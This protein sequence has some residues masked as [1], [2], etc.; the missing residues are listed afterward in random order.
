LV[1]RI[2]ID[3]INGCDEGDGDAP[4]VGNR[5]DEALRD[6]WSSAGGRQHRVKVYSELLGSDAQGSSATDPGRLAM[7]CK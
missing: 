1:G 2:A 4:F 3:E 5:G 6:G 7:M